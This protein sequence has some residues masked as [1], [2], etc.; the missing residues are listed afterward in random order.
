MPLLGNIEALLVLMRENKE[1]GRG[2]LDKVER[3]GVS[4]RGLRT[5]RQRQKGQ[6]HD[7]AHVGAIGYCHLGGV[8]KRDS[9]K[10]ERLGYPVTSIVGA[11]LLQ[12][13]ET[14]LLASV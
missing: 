14:R 5:A 7:D 2:A 11:G 10:E 4:L 9:G 1:D 13:F 8:R 6:R 12:R 3:N